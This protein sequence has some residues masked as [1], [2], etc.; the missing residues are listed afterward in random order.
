[1][2]NNSMKEI[3]RVLLE[4]QSVLIFP[5]INMDGDAVGSAVALCR[6]LR[7][8]GKDCWILAEDAMPG[9]LV[10]IGRGYFT[11]EHDLIKNADVSVCVDCG[12]FSRFPQRKD[13]FL[14]GKTTVCIDHHST[15]EE[16]CAY[17]YV[18]PMAAATGELIWMLL[19][20]MK[21][22]PDVEIG[23]AIFAA[24][25][26]DTGN[27]QYSNTTKNCHLIMAEL[28]DWGVDINKASVELYE[29]ERLA[30]LQITTRAL[31]TLEIIGP[32]LCQAAVAHVTLA[33]MEEVGAEPSETDGVIDRLR[34]IS[35]VEYA[36]FL[37]EKEPG[38]IR[39]SM[40]AKRRG[41]VAAIAS[42]YDG[43]GHIKAAGCTLYMS[44]EE[45]LAVMK[46]ELADAADVIA[47]ARE[48]EIV[49]KYNLIKPEK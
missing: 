45:A 32:R 24:I 19:K 25:A 6:Q 31:N 16:F 8:L 11:A 28:Y 14:E 2:A 47:A 20:E 21:A 1:M 27:F 38:V 44:M 9:N 30:K 23:Q 3:A 12:A 4:A 7:K 34:S 39:V 18:D 10:F 13:K 15:T 43:G 17:N 33:D 26:T 40:R 5:H 48:E 22:E 35:G 37:K 29:N 42:K 36:A 41:D 49:K 46:K